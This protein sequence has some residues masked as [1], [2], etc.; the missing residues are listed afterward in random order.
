MKWT[1]L[2][3]MLTLT[4]CCE[5]KYITQCPAPVNVPALN[6]YQTARMPETT[7]SA[8]VI[9]YMLT[10]LMLCQDTEAQL[11]VILKGYE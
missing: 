2:L 3:L 1:S 9:K 5:T 10:D 7:T 8:D 6:S 4:G 11:R